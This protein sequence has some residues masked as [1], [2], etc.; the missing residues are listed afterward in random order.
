MTKR[1]VLYIREVID[2]QS[3]AHQLLTLT[4]AARVRGWTVVQ[5]YVDHAIGLVKNK[6]GE[7]GLL[8]L[9]LALKRS[10]FDLILVFSMNILGRSLQGLAT[11]LADVHALNV[12]LYVHTHDIDT[13]QPEGKS[14]FCMCK[15]FAEFERSILKERVNRGIKGARLNGTKLGRPRVSLEIERQILNYRSQGMAIKTIAIVLKTGVSVVQRVLRD[16]PA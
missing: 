8:E 4:E 6:E 14:L 11:F 10:E 12:D 7:E 3:L 2:G 5:T 13:T 15:V 16:N 9:G 1:A